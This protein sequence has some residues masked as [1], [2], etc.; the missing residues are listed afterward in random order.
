MIHLT[1][2]KSF[3]YRH[4]VHPLEA[5]KDIKGAFVLID[6]RKAGVFPA[7]GARLLVLLSCSGFPLHALAVAS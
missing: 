2:R 5:Y 3:R 7:M 4:L 1:F 6:S